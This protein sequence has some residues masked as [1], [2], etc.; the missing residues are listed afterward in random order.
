[1]TDYQLDRFR[2]SLGRISINADRCSW[3]LKELDKDMVKFIGKEKMKK[4]K[5]CLNSVSEITDLLII[6][7]NG[8]I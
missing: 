7:S 5:I 8:N 4:L 1:M 3:L 6:K 2:R